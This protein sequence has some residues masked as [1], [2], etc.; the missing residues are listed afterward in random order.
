MHRRPQ[1]TGSARVCS[2]VEGK[3]RGWRKGNACGKH[4]G[5][6]KAGR[7]AGGKMPDRWRNAGGGCGGVL[8]ILG[9]VHCADTLGISLW[10]ELKRFQG[11]ERRDIGVSANR[12]ESV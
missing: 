5:C 1:V 2:L 6:V 7:E 8:R 11:K 10:K 3:G 9:G 12:K 4:S